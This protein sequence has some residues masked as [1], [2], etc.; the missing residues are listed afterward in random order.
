MATYDGITYF[1]TCTD[2]Y[3]SI[4]NGKSQPHPR[5]LKIIKKFINTYNRKNTFI[6]IGAHI[7]TV[8]IPYSKLFNQVICFEP[9]PETFVN[10]K[11]NIEYNKCNNILSYNDAISN[12]NNCFKLIKS[13]SNSGC[14]HIQNYNNTNKKTIT[15]DELNINNKI[16]FIKIDTVGSEL[17]VLEGAINTINKN[18]P[19]IQVET[20]KLSEINFNY[21]K[22]KIYNFLKNL[23]YIIYD[24]DNDDPIFIHNDTKTM[25]KYNNDPIFI[26]NDTK[27][28]NKYN[29]KYIY[30][31]DSLRN[32]GIYNFGDYITLFI[33][34]SIFLTQP[35]LDINGGSKNEDVIIGAGTILKDCKNNSIIWGTGLSSENDIIVKPKKIISVRGPLTRN[36]L[37]KIGIECPENYGDIGLILPYFYHP[38]INKKYKLG[39]IPH[40]IDKK[41]FNS[42]YKN[43]DENVKIIDV[44]KPIKNVINEILECEMTISSS[45]HGIIV[46]HAY[47]IKCMW[48]KITDK[49]LSGIFKF[50]DYYGSLEIDNYN[51]MLPY[52]YKEQISLQD[53]TQ[54]IDNYPNPKFPI[55]TKSILETCPFY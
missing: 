12:S 44:S 35:I 46:S 37:L 42:I 52:I 13:G 16:D 41:T 45:L 18:K 23:G 29:N 22:S 14:Y 8:S 54:L 53:I 17:Y 34:K 48:I 55:N 4:I 19:L 32:E 20:N 24:D 27:T 26:H 25:N 7:G 47:N 49:I 28:M 38:I 40:Y 43:N 30:Y 10:L 21:D 6:D 51:Q 11:K 5:E 15:L 50:R 36:R 2:F 3:N 31:Y 39:I 33:Y 1:G 9:N